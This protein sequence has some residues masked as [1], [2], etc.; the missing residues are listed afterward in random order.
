MPNRAAAINIKVYNMG[1]GSKI[2]PFPNKRKSYRIDSVYG[3][4]TSTST[5]IPKSRYQRQMKK[6]KQ[7]AMIYLTIIAIW[8]KNV[9]IKAKGF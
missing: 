3:C 5:D 7:L 1:C 4:I 8:C 9:F 6:M 2:I